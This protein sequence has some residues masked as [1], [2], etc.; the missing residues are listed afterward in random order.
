MGILHLWHVPSRIIVHLRST[1]I[2]FLLQAKITFSLIVVQ[3]IE[4]ELLHG[5]KHYKHLPMCKVSA[6]IAED[7]EG[8]QMP[9]LPA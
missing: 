5:H 1:D 8:V 9:S 2:F 7:L 4:R 3:V 6:G